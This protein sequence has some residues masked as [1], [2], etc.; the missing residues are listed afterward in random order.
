MEPSKYGT[1]WSCK[2]DG[3][4]GTLIADGKVVKDEILQGHGKMM[5]GL[6]YHN[7]F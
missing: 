6:A 1:F 2:Q 4:D 3:T 7:E 5:K